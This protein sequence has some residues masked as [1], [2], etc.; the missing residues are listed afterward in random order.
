MAARIGRTADMPIAG[1]TF[2]P[3]RSAIIP[4]NIASIAATPHETPIIRE[5]AVLA[6]LGIAS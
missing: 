5:D 3:K 6:P 4:K 2:P 1:T